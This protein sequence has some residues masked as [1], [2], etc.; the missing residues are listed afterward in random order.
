MLLPT[1]RSSPSW[2]KTTRFRL[3]PSLSLRTDVA[4]SVLKLKEGVN[5]KRVVLCQ[6]GDDLVV[7][8]STGRLLRLELNEETL[9][10]MGPSPAGS[11]H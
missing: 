10:V 5:L 4:T 11:P 1:T 7:G 6:D 9:P 3:T 2:H 8:S